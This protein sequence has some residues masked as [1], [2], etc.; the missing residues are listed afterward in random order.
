V[1]VIGTMAVFRKTKRLDILLTAFKQ[2]K[3]Q[4]VPFKG[5]IAGAGVLRPYL[6]FLIWRWGLKS[7][8]ELRPWVKDKEAFYNDV[9]IF[10]V[11]SKRETF[12]ICL[13]EAMARKKA[14]ISTACGGP[15]EII[16]HQIDGLLTEVNQVPELT[17]K[18]VQL[19]QDQALRSRLAEAG[20][21]KVQQKYQRSVVQDRMISQIN[22]MVE[23]SKKV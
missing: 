4:G 21:Q 20:Y 1:P 3:E 22:R 5:I 14:V 16:E 12:N 10:A 7:Q 17:D 13:I 8:V 19:V 11:T 23:K 15:N 9:D 2:L 18:L 6:Q